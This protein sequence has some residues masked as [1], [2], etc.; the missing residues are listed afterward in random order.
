MNRLQRLGALTGLVGVLSLS[1][2]S[3][4]DPAEPAT[5]PTASESSSAS[6]TET[7]EPSAE[8]ASGAEM[9]GDDAFMRAPEGYRVSEFGFGIV[10]ADKAGTTMTFAD[11]GAVAVTSPRQLADNGL[12]NFRGRPEVSYDAELDGE[13]AY[14]AVGR[15]SSGPYVEYGAVRGGTAVLVSF[16]FRA[17]TPED[18]QDALIASVLAS[19]GWT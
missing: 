8:P 18:E 16:A 6:P 5:T 7:E 1:G 2:C 13:P 14:V 9:V 4:D 17:G 19:F 11:L 12:E 15:D 3:G 10:N